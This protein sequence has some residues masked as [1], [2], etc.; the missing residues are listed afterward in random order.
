MACGTIVMD[1]RVSEKGEVTDIEVRRA[2]SSLT[3]GAVRSVRAWTFEPARFNGRA[4]VSRITVAITFN[5]ASEQGATPS[6]PPIIH[7]DDQSRIQSS[8][9]PA[10]VTFATLP[11]YPPNAEQITAT[12][13]LEAIVNKAGKARSTKVLRDVP[14]FTAIAIHAV[15]DW[16]FIP[17]TLN[18]RPLE[19]EVVLAFFFRQPASGP[20]GPTFNICIP[21]ELTCN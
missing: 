3:E 1:V 19:S 21:A 11:R 2:I 17:A 9:Q 5:P 20:L 13:A 6:L 7:Q 14:P 12:V 4:V 18:G 15:D 10:E 8:F 16:R